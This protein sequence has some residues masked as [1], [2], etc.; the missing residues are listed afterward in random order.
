MFYW[1]TFKKMKPMRKV[2]CLFSQGFTGKS[3]HGSS[4][5]LMALYQIILIILYEFS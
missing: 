3:T 2:H 5:W 4:N 1:S